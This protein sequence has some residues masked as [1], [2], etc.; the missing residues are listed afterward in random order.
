[1]LQVH[2]FTQMTPGAL[3]MPLDGSGWRLEAVARHP[4]N[5]AARKSVDSPDYHVAFPSVCKTRGGDLLIVYREAFT[6][7]VSQDPHDGKIAL[8]RSRDGGLTWSERASN[9]SPSPP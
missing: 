3:P 5:T 7:A 4:R 8:I 2:D 1:M 9:Y 6:H